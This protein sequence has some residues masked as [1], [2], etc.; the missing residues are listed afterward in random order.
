LITLGL[1]KPPQNT[2]IVHFF[3]IDIQ[4]LQ[5]MM[6]SAR[7]DSPSTIEELA[8]KRRLLALGLSFAFSLSVASESKAGLFKR[9]RGTCCPQQIPAC[10]VVPVDGTVADSTGAGTGTGSGTDTGTA[11]NPPVKTEPIPASNWKEFTSGQGHYRIMFPGTPKATQQ[12]INGTTQFASTMEVG[13]TGFVTVYWDQP[14]NMV[15]TLDAA[16]RAY[17]GGVRGTIQ[18]DKAIAIGDYPGR[19]VHIH[20]AT[21]HTIR[22]YNVKQRWYVVA[23]SGP[24]DSGDLRKY[25]DS[26]RVD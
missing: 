21:P 23:V 18:S 14:A 25:L 3:Y 17:A 26:F 19:E 10:D 5:F 2:Q 1:C 16:V 20:A 22:I 15:L 7:C 6:V 4:I 24:I 9:H 12:T 8:M 11:T 13:K